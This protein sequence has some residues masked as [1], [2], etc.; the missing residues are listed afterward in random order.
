MNRGLFNPTIPGRYWLT[1]VQQLVGFEPTEA[2]ELVHGV[3]QVVDRG[4]ALAI[5]AGENLWLGEGVGRTERRRLLD[6]RQ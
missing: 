3:L 5:I 1:I 4:D 2:L 6:H